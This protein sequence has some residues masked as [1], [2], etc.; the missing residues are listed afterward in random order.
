MNR[1]HIKNVSRHGVTRVVAWGV[2]PCYT[3]R[4]QEFPR[5][6]VTF[7]G[8]AQHNPDVTPRRYTLTQAGAAG[9]VAV[10]VGDVFDYAALLSPRTQMVRDELTAELGRDEGGRPELHVHCHVSGVKVAPPFSDPTW[11]AQIF[12]AALPI[13]LS[14]I[15]WADRDFYRRHPEYNRARVLVHFHAQEQELDRLAA[16]GWLGEYALDEEDTP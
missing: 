3:S 6:F 9:S 5:T 13:A 4:M 11:R 14:A 1:C 15:H 12:E 2:A 10:A 7:I 8:A 16:Y